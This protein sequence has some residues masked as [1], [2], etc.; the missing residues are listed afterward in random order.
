M[1]R[2]L[3]AIPEHLRDILRARAKA[4][5]VNMSALIREILWYWVHNNM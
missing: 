2:I 4:K 1:T 5:G 3:L